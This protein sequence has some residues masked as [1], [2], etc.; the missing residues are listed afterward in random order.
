MYSVR[1]PVSNGISEEPFI[2]MRQIIFHK[3]LE[4]T[5]LSLSCDGIEVSF[6]G[7]ITLAMSKLI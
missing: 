2:G 6:S 5:K 4:E 1:I 7:V 3:E